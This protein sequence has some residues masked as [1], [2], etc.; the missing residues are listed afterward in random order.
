MLGEI[1][2]KAKIKIE[3]SDFLKITSIVVIGIVNLLL[4]LAVSLI[5]FHFFTK[6]YFN[7]ALFSELWNPV[8]VFVFFFLIAPYQMVSFA[9]EVCCDS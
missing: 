9:I 8:T 3:G 4:S 7:T 5:G 1:L 2:R 6:D